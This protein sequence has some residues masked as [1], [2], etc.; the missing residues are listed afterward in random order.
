[1]TPKR[2]KE[3][4][5]IDLF[6]SLLR[7]MRLEQLINQD[8][9]VVINNLFRERLKRRKT[10]KDP[11]YSGLVEPKEIPPAQPWKYKTASLEKDPLFDD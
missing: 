5:F 3:L 2:E 6:E 1:M 4:G 11:R 10:G 9:I 8:D 7:M